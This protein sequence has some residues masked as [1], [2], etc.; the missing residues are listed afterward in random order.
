MTHANLAVG[1]GIVM[2]GWPGPHTATPGT[3]ARRVTKRGGALETPFVVD[4]VYIRV[5]DIDAHFACAR[6][7]GAVILGEIEANE[8]VGQRQYR[9]EDVE[10]HRWMFARAA[11]QRP[12]RDSR[13]GAGARRG[14]MR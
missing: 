10:G 8:A 9:A 5:D 3:T 4:G 14:G 12:S 13:E 6:E 7:A 1:D 2:V 11:V